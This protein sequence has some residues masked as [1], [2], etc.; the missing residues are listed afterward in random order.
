MKKKVSASKLE[1]EQSQV[2]MECL[3]SVDIGRAKPKTLQH[4][5]LHTRVLYVEALTT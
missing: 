1:R 5:P 3:Y 2:K 4:H